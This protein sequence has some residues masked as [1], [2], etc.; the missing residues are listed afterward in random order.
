LGRDV[1][2]GPTAI[3]GD[4]HG[5]LLKLKSLLA[6]LGDRRLVFLGD[7]VNRGPESRAV[8]EVVAGLVDD[9]RA[10]LVRGNHEVSLLA[11]SQGYLSFVEFALMGGLPTLRSYL[12]DAR[13]D[14]RTA[15]RHALPKR[16]RQ[17]LES[18]VDEIWIGPTLAR[19]WDADAEAAMQT[20][21]RTA[22]RGCPLVVGHTVV[23]QAER[24]GD[25][26]F[27]DSG[28]GVGGALSAF[29][30]PEETILSSDT[31]SVA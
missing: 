18:A 17:L 21:I 3:I 20:R 13:G 23:K 12:P 24:V 1:V 11:F 26:V 6:Q 22:T 30:L 9:G 5:D 16:H 31:A 2:T 4:V 28:C 10:T 8:V 14:V 29:L 27:L 15:F 19:H 25:V 7:L